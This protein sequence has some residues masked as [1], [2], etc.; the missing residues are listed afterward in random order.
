MTG[1]GVAVGVAVSSIVGEGDNSGSA[2]L[3][4]A[5]DSWENPVATDKSIPKSANHK[6]FVMLNEI[7]T[8]F[9]NNKQRE[10]PR[11]LPE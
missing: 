8:S 7:R 9:A 6:G 3:T 4:G 11:L 1:V 10:I 5:G 2:G